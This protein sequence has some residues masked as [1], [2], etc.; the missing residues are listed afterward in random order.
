[1]RMGKEGEVM[2]KK[3][4]YT[5]WLKVKD[6]VTAF[7]YDNYDDVQNLIGYLVDGARY[8]E[9]TISKKEVQE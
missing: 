7:T 9:I 6:S 8:L 5:V 1:M 4:E 3:Y 2:N